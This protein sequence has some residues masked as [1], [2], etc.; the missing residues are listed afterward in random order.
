MPHAAG[1]LVRVILI[2]IVQNGRNKENTQKDHL[3]NLALKDSCVQLQ[4]W[5]PHNSEGQYWCQ[6]NEKKISLPF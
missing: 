3:Y 6:D 1:N 5:L 4:H 2:K